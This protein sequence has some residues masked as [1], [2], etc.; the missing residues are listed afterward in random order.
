MVPL[1]R[2]IWRAGS[3]RHKTQTYH[4]T[5]TITEIWWARYIWG[6]LEWKWRS[7]IVR[8]IVHFETQSDLHTHTHKAPPHTHTYSTHTHLRTYSHM[9]SCVHAHTVYNTWFLRGVLAVIVQKPFSVLH[10][11]FFCKLFGSIQNLFWKGDSIWHQKALK[12]ITNW[13]DVAPKKDSAMNHLVE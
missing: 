12:G 1:T 8:K 7:C 10:R 5:K 4:K 2:Q 6:G 3:R 9:H 13:F 11:N